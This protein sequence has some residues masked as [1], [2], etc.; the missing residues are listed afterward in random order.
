MQIQNDSFAGR[1]YETNLSLKYKVECK[2]QN[3][4]KIKNSQNI[5]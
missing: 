3:V 1:N 4:E 5:S 2:M